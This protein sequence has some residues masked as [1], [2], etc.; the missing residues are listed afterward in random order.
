MS[1]VARDGGR[2][3][4]VIAVWDRLCVPVRGDRCDPSGGVA[5]QSMTVNK[6]PQEG[7]GQ[8]CNIYVGI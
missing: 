2:A 6:D 3:F 4:L 8:L 7:D 5:V 1:P